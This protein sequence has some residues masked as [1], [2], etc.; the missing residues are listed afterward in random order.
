MLKQKALIRESKL[1]KQSQKVV[2]IVSVKISSV[3]PLIGPK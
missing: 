2:A 1:L 3:L